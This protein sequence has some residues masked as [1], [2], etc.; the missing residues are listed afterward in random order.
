VHRVARNFDVFTPP[1]WEW[2]KEDGTF[3]NRFDD[4]S[5]ED[6]MSEEERFRIIYCSS[7]LVGAFGETI[8]RFRKDVKL[9]AGLEIIEDADPLDPELEGGVVPEDWRL[10]RRKASTLL[11]NSL[12]FA[13]FLSPKSLVVLRR[14]LAPLLVRLGLEDFDLSSMTGPQRR[15]TQG[16]ARYVYELTTPSGQP[17]FTGIR[18]PSRL[19]I[20]WE[21]W[22]IFDDRMLHTQDETFGTIRKDDHD[23]QEAAAFL[24][25]DIE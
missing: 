20:N 14:E 24:E 6:G 11:D 19:N 21:L 12:L 3:G 15:L 16:A 5:A 2:A 1:D 8:A 22:A 23:L 10:E 18:Y 17:I 25:I 7:R 13:D 9:H 4:P